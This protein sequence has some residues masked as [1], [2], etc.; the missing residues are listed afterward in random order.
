MTTWLAWVVV[1]VVALGN[2]CLLA[3]FFAADGDPLPP[4]EDE[5]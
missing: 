4:E 2:L 3:L 5:R 1:G